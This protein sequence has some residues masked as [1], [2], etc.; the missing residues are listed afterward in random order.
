V[1]GAGAVDSPRDAPTVD[2]HD[3]V[4]VD[5]AID[6]VMTNFSPG[7]RVT[8][9]WAKVFGI[10]DLTNAAVRLSTAGSPVSD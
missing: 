6:G 9:C 4:D 8:L 10:I 3:V 7:G 2:V 1:P 5:G